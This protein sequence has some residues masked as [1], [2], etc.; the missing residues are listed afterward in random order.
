[1]GEVF[2]EGRHPG[3]AILTEATGSRSRDNA[4]IEAGAGV[5]EAG[6]VL[7]AGATAGEYKPAAVADTAVAVAIYGA[8]ASAQAVAISIIARDAEMNGA[9]LVFEASVTTDEQKAAKVAD[10]ASKGVIVR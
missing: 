3:E 1:M 4:I 9:C 2:T 5:F 8:D 10:L 7:A 6:T